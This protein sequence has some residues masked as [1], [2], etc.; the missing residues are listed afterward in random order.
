MTCVTRSK[1]AVVMSTSVIVASYRV[2]HI[3]ISRTRTRSVTERAV[4]MPVVPMVAM[5]PVAIHR[6]TCPMMPPMG[7]EIPVVRRGP[8]CPERI[9]EPIVDVRTVDVDRLYHI[10]RAVY[11]FVT[12]HLRGDFTRDLVF[13]HVD[14]CHVL[15]NI[16]CQH[17]LYYH[18]VLVVGGGL[19]HAQVIHYTIA[20][21]VK[22][23]ESRIG[24][25]EKRLKLLNVLHST[26]ER[27]H[28]FQIERLAY[29]FAVGCNGNRLVSPSI[30]THCGQ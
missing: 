1:R 7:V 12:Y 11:I 25:I 27:S 3:M 22:I 14:G 5:V 26:E 21:E 20:V 30:P 17:G 4:G 13:L 23:R 10:V 9:P 16:L 28:R 2:T 15:E 29:I 8:T 19:Y 24:V 18:K 6:P